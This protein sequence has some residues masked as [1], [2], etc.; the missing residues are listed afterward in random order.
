MSISAEEDQVLQN[1]KLEFILLYSSQVCTF[2]ATNKVDLQ[3][4]EAKA[5]ISLMW[6]VRM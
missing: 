3:P 6:K 5:I 1:R 4:M 2:K